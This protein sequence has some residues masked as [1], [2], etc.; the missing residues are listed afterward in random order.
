MCSILLST[1]IH[2]YYIDFFPPEGGIII[3]FLACEHSHHWPSSNVTSLLSTITIVYHHITIALSHIDITLVYHQRYCNNVYGEAYF[4][5]SLT[6]RRYV[7]GLLN[8]VYNV[9][10]TWKAA[11]GRRLYFLFL[12]G[13]VFLKSQSVV[14][15]KIFTSKIFTESK[16]CSLD[17]LVGSKDSSRLDRGR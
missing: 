8:D 15:Q 5:C 13:Q 12:Q 14:L 16:L 11:V 1:F 6:L 2:H 7:E 3:I 9:S 10:N 4:I 17:T